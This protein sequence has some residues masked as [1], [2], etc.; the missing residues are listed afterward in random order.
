MNS[1]RF[2]VPIV[3][4]LMVFLFASQTVF[5]AHGQQ[6]A[7]LYRD[8]GF[9]GA[10]QALYGDVADLDRTS[11]GNN[12]SSSIG[13]P[14]GCRVRLYADTGFRG[15]RV[16]LN[17]DIRDLGRT[18]FGNDRVSSLKVRCGWD[19]DWG[20]EGPVDSGH[21][22]HGGHGGYGHGGSGHDGHGGYGHDGHGGYGHDGHDDRGHDGHGHGGYGHDDH[23]HGAGSGPYGKPNTRPSSRR[24]RAVLFR[25]A[26]YRG[27]DERFPA[28][29][30]PDLRDTAI[31]N[32]AV[33]SLEVRRGCRVRLY[34][35]TEFRGDYEE[36][37]YNVPDLRGTRIGNDRA[38]SMQVRCGG[39]WSWDGYQRRGGVILFSDADFEG[40]DERFEFD[41]P[42]L[43][44]T[45]IGSDTASSIAV[46]R[47]CRVRL[48]EDVG[49]R[50]RSVELTRDEAYLGQTRI[51]NDR[52][53]SLKVY[54]RN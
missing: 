32:D 33:S 22:G 7:T 41:V 49:F 53:S 43:R 1:P 26:G 6:T 34:Q 27:R 40:Y 51:G 20:V 39:N 12:R 42:D 18:A 38:S 50:G 28:G 47:G 4:F 15:P 9:R 16:E 5:A 31:G 30:Y 2:S 17:A 25:D 11:I 35:D 8:A 45:Q 3:S 14:L 10:H 19:R 52:V 13:V 29:D 23:G 36:I 21:G 24:G 48:F 46:D 37:D 44:E 54:C